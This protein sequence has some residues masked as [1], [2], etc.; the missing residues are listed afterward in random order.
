MRSFA[1]DTRSFLI[2][3][4]QAPGVG[5]VSPK[6]SF[7][8]YIYSGSSLRN[9]FSNL[10][11]DTSIRV[12]GVT[13]QNYHASVHRAAHTNIDFSWKFDTIRTNF[14][15]TIILQSTPVQLQEI[16]IRA[17]RRMYKRGDTLF[18]PVDSIKTM[19]HASAGEL[20][21]KI[22]G[23]NV[24]ADGNVSVFGKKVDK[25]RVDGVEV[26]GGNSKATL[27]NLRADMLKDVAVINSTEG[28]ARGVEL[29]LKLKKDRN[30]GI[31]GELYGQQGTADRTN[32]GFKLNEIKPGTF[33][34]SFFNYN[35]QNQQVLSPVDYFQ[36]V[37]LNSISN[38]A[39]G[40]QKLYYD[41]KLEDPFNSLDKI[42][43]LFPFLPKGL[44]RTFSGGMNLSKTY[45]KITWN[46]YLLGSHDKIYTNGTSDFIRNLG[47][48]NSND[49]ENATTHNSILDIVGQSSLKWVPDDKNMVS[50]KVILERKKIDDN[51]SMLLNSL[52]YND[53]DSL[54][55]DLTLNNFQQTTNANNLLFLNGNWEHRYNKPAEKTTFSAGVA[56]NRLEYNNNAYN[57]ASVN[58]VQFENNNRIA[59][60][61]TNYNYFAN[62]QHSIPL[63]RKFLIDFRIGTLYSSNLVNRT[64]KD[65]LANQAPLLNAA[66]SVNN[67][68]VRNNQT[69]A[70]TFLFYK[71]GS[72][73]I[74]A[75][76]GALITNWDVYAGDTTYNRINKKV[77]LPGL[78]LNYAIGKSKVSLRVLREQATP[79]T[80][81][82]LPVT[83]S[84][85]IQ[86]VNR[87]NP[88]LNPY[89]TNKYEISSD[90]FIPKMGSVNFQFNYSVTNQPVTN[91]YLLENGLYPLLTFTQYKKAKTITGSIVYMNINQST[92][93]NPYIF[94][95]YL[96]Q[97]QYQLNEQMVTPVSFNAISS[98]A[99]VKM[100]ITKEHTL[101]LSVQSTINSTHFPTSSGGTANRFNV[102]LK[103][104]NKITDGLY[105]KFSTKW[106]LIHAN[107]DNSAIKPVTNFNI[108][109]YVGKGQ[110]WQL[111]CGVSNIFNVDEI[112]LVNVGLTQ[113]AI[114]TYNYLS[115]YVNIGVT[116]Y[117]E[118]WKM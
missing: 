49:V 17:Q 10:Q 51:P 108:Y 76:A 33:L 56:V 27:E 82:L 9:I 102:E 71:A 43:E 100:N 50:A 113:R 35:N 64:G 79:S 8:L 25:I 24:S 57:K 66:L 1:Q 39:L 118:K 90:V 78:Y 75:G 81:T 12:L 21:D 117:P 53:L 70:Q 74:I 97:N 4:S 92:L 68:H 85:N 30:H 3:F 29:D 15:K 83:D 41:N 45:R 112:K 58:G 103:D 6:A 69:V 38:N 87:G 104:N 23:A 26:F 16:N 65:I 67:F 62:V 88:I 95:F 36:I 80:N 37:G 7:D 84:S 19:P 46:S 107:G 111:N 47:E 20:L 72:L 28:G 77:F 42:G 93:L 96:W 18:I 11:T 22:P 55:N 48:L 14:T 31:Y 116:F 91:N 86:R 63:S 98:T 5:K 59:Q 40:T 89:I 60:T 44:H 105:Y 106:I 61:N 34:N 54:L 101:N 52:L 99:G 109:K 115:R 2:K 114:S 94:L 110:K 73:S 13:G 32:L